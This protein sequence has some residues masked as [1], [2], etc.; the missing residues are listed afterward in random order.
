MAKLISRERERNL[1]KKA[2]EPKYQ[3]WTDWIE[4]E[5][6]AGLTERECEKLLNDWCMEELGDQMFHTFEGY[7][8]RNWL[9]IEEYRIVPDNFDVDSYNKALGE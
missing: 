3:P 5:G 4:C 2:S 9:G 7:Q 1:M 6:S 8:I